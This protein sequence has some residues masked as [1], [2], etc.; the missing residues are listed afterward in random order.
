MSINV[1]LEGS[2][3]SEG[4]MPGEGPMGI[5]LTVHSMALRQRQD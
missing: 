5:P 2:A 4:K 3:L 1:T